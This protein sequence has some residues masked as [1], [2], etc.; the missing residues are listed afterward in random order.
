M[1]TTPNT[2]E[3]TQAT[4]IGDATVEPGK[5]TTVPV[6]PFGLA[7]TP[8]D[9]VFRLSDDTPKTA[10]STS[11]ER[12]TKGQQYTLVAWI[13]NFDTQPHTVTVVTLPD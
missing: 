8:P 7:V 12:V 11:V 9:L 5:H 6:G 4:I 3:D 1:P 13:W 2:P 10:I